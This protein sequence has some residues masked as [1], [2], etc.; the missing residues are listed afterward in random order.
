MSFVVGHR[1]IEVEGIFGTITTFNQAKYMKFLKELV[2]N[3]KERQG[4]D[5]RKS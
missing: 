4:V 3:A 5:Q 2:L 1:E